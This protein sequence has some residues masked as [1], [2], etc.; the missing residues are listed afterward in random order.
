MM[1]AAFAATALA[2]IAVGAGGQLAPGRVT[3]L[4]NSTVTVTRLHF[5]AGA[6]ETLHTHP[7]PLL[8]VQVSAGAIEISDR[9]V[10][11]VGSRP[12]EAWFI[13]ANTRHAAA[14]R[15]GGGVDMLAIAIKPDRQPAPA[16]PPT[17]APPG[18]SRATL[19]D[20]DDVR[21]VRVRFT[22]EGR[23]P[24]HSHPNDLLTVQITKGKVE[25]LDGTDRSTRDCEPGFARFLARN[26][27]HAYAS[28][29][30]NPFELLS[31]SIK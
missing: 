3:V 2:M 29:D 15:S 17:E 6:A 9:E 14:N 30:I 23:E 8:I 28:A 1:R 11:R 27:A 10:I 18:I 13:A 26:V 19:I 31:V 22:P 7:Y 24:V 12:G 21:V 5:A 20:N 25:I 4:D 16:A